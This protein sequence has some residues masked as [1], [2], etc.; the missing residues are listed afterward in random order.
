M[1]APITVGAAYPNDQIRVASYSCTP[2]HPICRCDSMVSLP[3][4]SQ[5]IE[6]CRL[7]SCY[8]PSTLRTRSTVFCLRMMFSR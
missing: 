7:A 4:G 5:G 6:A 1:E 3:P 8:P 2:T